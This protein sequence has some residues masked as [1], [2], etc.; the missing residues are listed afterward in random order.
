M[1]TPMDELK[2]AMDKF[3]N[4]LFKALYIDKMTERLNSILIRIVNG[5]KRL[6]KLKDKDK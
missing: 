2:D 5:I 1:R 3:Q 4:E 6:S